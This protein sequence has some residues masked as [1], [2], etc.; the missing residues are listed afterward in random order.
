MDLQLEVET[1]R[2]VKHI[3]TANPRPPI[4]GLAAPDLVPALGSVLSTFIFLLQQL[5][6]RAHRPARLALCRISGHL[7]PPFQGS[8]IWLL[9]FSLPQ[10]FVCS[11]MSADQR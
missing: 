11:H 7:L 2:L 5:V 4:I 8:F 10:I 3:Y 6:Y 9:A 1:S